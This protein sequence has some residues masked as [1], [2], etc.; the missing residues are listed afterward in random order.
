MKA[1]KY[2][3]AEFSNY[4]K[5]MVDF[6]AP[7]VDVVSIAPDN[8]YSVASGTSFSAPVTSGVAA[9]LWSYFPEKTA[10]QIK[11]AMMKSVTDFSTSQVYLPGGR[12][13]KIKVLFGDLS[14]TGGVVN[15]YKAFLYLQNAN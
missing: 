3:P 2:L 5:T 12:A 11:E 4:G 6:F 9:L 1:K 10:A 7:G 8:K 15:A 14:I 13:D